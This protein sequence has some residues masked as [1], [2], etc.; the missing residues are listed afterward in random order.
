MMLTIQEAAERLRVSASL[1]YRLVR[2]GALPCIRVGLGQGRLRILAAD[3]ESY[4]N[5]CREGRA[6][7]AS[8]GRLAVKLKHVR[9]RS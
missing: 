9:V 2:N 6:V 4:V 8:P 3:L 1:V 7:D 5:W